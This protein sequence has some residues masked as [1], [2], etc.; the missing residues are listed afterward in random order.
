MGPLSDEFSRV[1]REMQLGKGRADALQAL[2]ERTNVDDLKSFVGSMVQADAF[3]ISIGQVLRVQTG[4]I[5]VKRRQHA[6]KRRPSRC[7]SRS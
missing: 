3:G 4:E 5:R 1:L 2:A 7:R 6:E